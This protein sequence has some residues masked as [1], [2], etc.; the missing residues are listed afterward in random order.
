VECKNNKGVISMN[1]KVK[2][3]EKIET[4]LN[5][6]KFLGIEDLIKRIALKKRGDLSPAENEELKHLRETP[7]DPNLEKTLQALGKKGTYNDR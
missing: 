3:L 1:I 6:L 4:T 2:R 7:I 5:P